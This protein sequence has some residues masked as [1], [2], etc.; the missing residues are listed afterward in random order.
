MLEK[1]RDEIGQFYPADPDGSIPVAY[2]WARTVKC[3]NPACGA[4]IPLVRQLWLC[5]KDKRKLAMR[6]IPD[7]RASRC[8]FKVVEGEPFDFS[9]DEGTMR[10]GNATC[11]FC[12]QVCPSSHIK[13]EGHAGQID[14]QMMAVVTV[15]PGKSGKRYRSAVAEDS[16]ASGLND[17]M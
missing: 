10:R 8:R 16:S 13:T 5:K 9:P 2:L 17:R 4:M 12:S 6:M 15:S 3:P 7:V 14:R 1:A 11:P